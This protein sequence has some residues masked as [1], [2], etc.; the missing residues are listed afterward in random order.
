MSNYPQFLIST[1]KKAALGRVYLF[2]AKK[3]KFLGEILSFKSMNDFELFKAN[4]NKEYCCKIND[5]FYTICTYT[6]AKGKIIGLFVIDFFDS[7]LDSSGKIITEGL[8]N[9]AASWLKAYYK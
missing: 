3:P 4:P 8:M 2:H 9:E 1:N 6:E 5:Q 7:P